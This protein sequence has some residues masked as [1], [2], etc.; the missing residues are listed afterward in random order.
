MVLLSNIG[1]LP[2]LRQPVA[3]G[4]KA[5]GDYDSVRPRCKGFL[6]GR[7]QSRSPI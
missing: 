5:V 7:Y 6:P 3:V 2:G 1:T 4:F